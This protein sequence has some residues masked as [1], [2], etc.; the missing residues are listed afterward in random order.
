MEHVQRYPL[1]LYN[2]AT[3]YGV[4]NSDAEEQEKRAEGYGDLADFWRVVD[5]K[6]EFLHQEKHEEKKKPGRPRK[7]PD[8]EVV[9]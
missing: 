6:E 2:I 8:P 9:E 3:T 1:T 5:G 4:V 7:E